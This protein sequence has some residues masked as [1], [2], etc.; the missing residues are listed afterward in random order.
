MSWQEVRTERNELVGVGRPIPKH[1]GCPILDLSSH[2]PHVSHNMRQ[3]I[4]DQASIKISLKH[5]ARKADSA[6]EHQPCLR[7]NDSKGILLF[8]QPF[9]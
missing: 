2:T 7:T 8:P 6:L 5:P 9:W 4:S 3:L 1:L